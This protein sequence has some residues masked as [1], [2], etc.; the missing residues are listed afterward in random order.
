MTGLA[1][2]LWVLARALAALGPEDRPSFQPPD[3]GLGAWLA[4]TLDYLGS[5]VSA[6]QPTHGSMLLLAGG[7]AVL[8]PLVL[9]LVLGRLSRILVA[10]LGGGLAVTGGLLLVLGQIRRSFLP[11]SWAGAALWASVAVVISWLGLA[12]QYRSALTA[13]KED[14]QQDEKDEKG[15][16]KAAQDAEKE[17]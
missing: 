1:V 8:A 5:A 11:S 15:K 2:V 13:K 4:E 6:V 16:T 9:L 12:Y 14:S 17:K 3:V 7:L 10:S